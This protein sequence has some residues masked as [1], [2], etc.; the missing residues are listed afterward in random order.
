M[1]EKMYLQLQ[2]WPIHTKNT[3]NIVFL[4]YQQIN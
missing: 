1:T 3:K 2:T 4:N